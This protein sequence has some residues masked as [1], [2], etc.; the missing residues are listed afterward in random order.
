MTATTKKIL[1]AL[2]GA[3]DLRTVRLPLDPR[4]L[5]LDSVATAAAEFAELCRVRV[6][7]GNEAQAILSIEVGDQSRGPRRELIGEILNFILGH[8]T[9]SYVEEE[10]AR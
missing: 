3:D 10:P 8:A 4:V 9:R 5:P 6:S 2:A 1:S 7:A